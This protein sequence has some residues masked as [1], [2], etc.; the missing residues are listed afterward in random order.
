MEKRLV[1]VADINFLAGYDGLEAVI[2]MTEPGDIYVDFVLADSNM[3]WRVCTTPRTHKREK[4]ERSFKALITAANLLINEGFPEF[5]VKQSRRDLC[6]P[7][8]HAE[9]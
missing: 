6:A 7:N 5:T 8:L 3:F 9:G 1:E 2:L 4:E